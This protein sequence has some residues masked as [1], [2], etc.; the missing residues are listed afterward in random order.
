[1][2]LES[3]VGSAQAGTQTSCMPGRK[4]S[5][6]RGAKQGLTQV[7]EL[8]HADD[9]PEHVQVEEPGEAL[10]VDSSC[11]QLQRVACQLPQVCKAGNAI[12]NT[13]EC[14]FRRGKARDGSR[15]QLQRA[16]SQLSHVCSA[17]TAVRLGR[18]E[19]QGIVLMNRRIEHAE[20]EEPG[21]A[22]V[23]DGSR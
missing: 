12:S 9:C 2:L 6:A 17:G 14:R 16:A 11:Q 7:V 19:Q 3:I 23:V 15:Q 21:E 1:M 13:S 8:E 22:L 18:R 5:C 4:M 20:K 10:I